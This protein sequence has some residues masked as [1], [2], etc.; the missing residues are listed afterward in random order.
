MKAESLAKA[1]IL[2]HGVRFSTRALQQADVVK[3]KRQNMVYNLPA[4]DPLEGTSKSSAGLNVIGT[5]A[6]LARPQELFLVGDDG[7]TVCV[8]AVSPVERRECATVD[9]RD[10]RLTLDTP[11]QP[12]VGRRLAAAEYVPQPAYYDLH[13]TSGRP[14]SRWVS[15][16]GYDEMN[17]W[18]W[19]DCA[20]GQTCSFCGINAVQ[21]GAGRRRDHP[22]LRQQTRHIRRHYSQPPRRTYRHQAVRI[23]GLEPG[24]SKYLSPCRYHFDS[25]R[26]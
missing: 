9:F 1:Y 21:K 2:T 3:A 15:A 10:N 22:R 24:A 4:A 26:D 23:S 5:N 6:R 12:D 8:S 11:G 14:V 25:V 13:T 7:Y 16:C 18:P 17:V 20:I 19:H